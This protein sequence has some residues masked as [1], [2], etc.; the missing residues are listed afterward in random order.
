MKKISKI[1]L[2]EFSKL[3]LEQRKMHVL[4]GGSGPCACDGWWGTEHV[5]AA[6]NDVANKVYP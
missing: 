4:R 6:Q 5:T 1:K 3:E 2:N